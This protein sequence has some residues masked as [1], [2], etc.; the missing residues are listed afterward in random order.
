LNNIACTFD[1]NMKLTSLASFFWAVYATGILGLAV[2]GSYDA[3]RRGMPK[4]TV[5]QDIAEMDE[6]DHGLHLRAANDSAPVMSQ[7][8]QL[9]SSKVS[10][11][12]SS[13]TTTGPA[14]GLGI[15]EIVANTDSRSVSVG[16]STSGGETII[17]ATIINSDTTGPASISDAS[18]ASGT[19]E[20]TT[21]TSLS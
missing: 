14:H 1:E 2:G 4:N 9:S 21:T 15:P 7:S 10:S 6:V 16:L 8:P 19:I 12:P 5:C 3:Q 17:I 13:L 11:A 20:V 18:V